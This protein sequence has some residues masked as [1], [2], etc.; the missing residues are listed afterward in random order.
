MLLIAY[1][2][3]LIF[4]PTEDDQAYINQMHFTLC[5]LISCILICN[6]TAIIF[7]FPATVFAWKVNYSV[8]CVGY[9]LLR[10]YI[11]IAESYVLQINFTF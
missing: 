7:T 4:Q 11:H 6:F 5:L 1:L 9:A 2:F 10:D 3:N 8:L